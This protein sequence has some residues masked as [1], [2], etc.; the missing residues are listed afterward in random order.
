MEEKIKKKPI[1][2]SIF[3]A[4]ALFSLIILLRV[5]VNIRKETTL[6][7]DKL[8]QEFSLREKDDKSYFNYATKDLEIY[9]VLYIP[10]INLKLIVYETKANTVEQVLENM[11]NAENYGAAHWYSLDDIDAG[12]GT[13]ALLSNHNG[14]SIGELFTHI[15]KLDF[16][17]KFYIKKEG[18]KY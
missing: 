10:K 4:I 11:E 5:D 6:Q 1:M 16:G 14:L 15:N 7:E 17:D 18:V 8:S 13:R 9:G 3:L 2:S 12:K